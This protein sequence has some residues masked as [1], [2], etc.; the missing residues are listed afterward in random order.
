[1][2][3]YI[4]VQDWDLDDDGRPETLRL[5]YA[6]PTA[7]LADGKSIR[8]QHAP[9]AFG[10][11]SLLIR[12]RLSKGRVLADVKAPERAPAKTLLRIRLPRGYKIM[13]AHAGKTP[14]RVDK[15]GAV[16][17]SSARGAFRVEFDVAKAT[18]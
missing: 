12:S 10:E 2:L 11:V 16:D 5:A 14:L 4:L 9:T 1:M 3:R 6:T 7:W 17:I 18:R 13:A 15:T 8:L